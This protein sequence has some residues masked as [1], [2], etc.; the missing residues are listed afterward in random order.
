L[1][2][3][4]GED[5]EA[6]QGRVDAWTATLKP[7]DE[8]EQY[9]AE[10]AARLSLQLD[11]IERAYVARVTANINDAAAGVS[12]PEAKGDD[13]LTL[14]ERLFWDARGPLSLY[15]H[16][17]INSY[18]DK[19][20]PLV[21]WSGDVNDPNN[22]E[23][24]VVSLE[25]TAQGCGWLLD[26]WAELAPRAGTSLAVARQAQGD[27]AITPAAGRRAIERSLTGRLLPP[28]RKLRPQ[29][30]RLHRSRRVA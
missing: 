5:A 20:Q 25:A 29:D 15:P 27:P 12:Q 11:R 13:V 24:L 3:L 7:R 10:R 30:N 2:V 22:P 16:S 8:I 9:L 6:C 28:R 18:T 4:S 14:G 23:Q 17:P 21:S 1:L 19:P 26:R